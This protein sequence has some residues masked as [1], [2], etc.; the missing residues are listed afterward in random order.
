M[1]V[2]VIKH[3]KPIFFNHCNWK[4]SS[5][6]KHYTDEDFEGKDNNEKFIACTRAKAFPLFQ[7]AINCT[8]AGVY[9]REQFEK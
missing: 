9:I 1:F 3:T 8:I 7:A 6:C 5:P 2:N 4:F